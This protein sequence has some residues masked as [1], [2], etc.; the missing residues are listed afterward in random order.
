MRGEG[1]PVVVLCDGLGCDGFAWKYLKPSLAERVR[2]VAFHYRG[3]GQST[4][5]P[6]LTHINVERF[7]ADLDGLL[8]HLGVG[9]AVLL[10]HSMGCQVALEFHRRFPHHVSALGLLCGSYGNPLDTFHDN[11]LLRL[12]FPALRDAVI[13]NPKIAATLLQKLGPTKLANRYGILTELN[14]ALAKPEDFFPYMVHLSRMD[15]VCF[16]RTL[17][18]LKDHSAWNHLPKIDVPT[19]V[20]GG[21]RDKFT[22]GWLSRRM[23]DHIPGAEYVLVPQG[24]HIA[25]LE[26]PALTAEAVDRLLARLQDSAPKA[27]A[28]KAAIVEP[29]AAS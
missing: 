10:G 1:E 25:N 23:A 6:D 13:A 24:S 21:E 17:D 5:G 20:L 14:P 3:H 15:P 26:R 22:P 9:A 18:S 4:T 2:V 11:S 12:V 19:L 8:N 28:P 16:V 29:R 7:C 27:T